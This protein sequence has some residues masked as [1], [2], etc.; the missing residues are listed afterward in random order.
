MTS[1][2]RADGSA[3]ARWSSLPSYDLVSQTNSILALEHP[4][5][6]KWGWVWESHSISLREKK[7]LQLLFHSHTKRSSSIRPQAAGHRQN[8]WCVTN[9][10][11]VTMPIYIAINRFRYSGQLLFFVGIHTVVGQMNFYL[12][13]QF[14]LLHLQKQLKLL[15]TALLFLIGIQWTK[16]MGKWL[17]MMCTKSERQWPI[18]Y[19]LKGESIFRSAIGSTLC[20]FAHSP[21]PWDYKNWPWLFSLSVSPLNEVVTQQAKPSACSGLQLSACVSWI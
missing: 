10:M 19:L 16:N 15:C 20:N 17:E 6:S 18:V 4:Q 8:M 11:D 12:I 13:L 14:K 2:Q 21:F 3:G 5:P 1:P 7:N 9:M